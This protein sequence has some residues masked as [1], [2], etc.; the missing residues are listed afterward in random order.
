MAG[1]GTLDGQLVS[2]IPTNGPRGI[3]FDRSGNLYL[4]VRYGGHVLKIDEARSDAKRGTLMDVAAR[5]TVLGNEV[6]QIPNVL[7]IRDPRCVEECIQVAI[8]RIIG[9]R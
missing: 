4:A 8:D 3:A 7:L 9:A 1:G 5:S 2:N 6:L